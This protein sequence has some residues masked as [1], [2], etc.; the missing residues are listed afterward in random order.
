M[1]F[2]GFLARPSSELA[3]AAGSSFDLAAKETAEDIRTKENNEAEAAK[4][5]AKEAQVAK[6]QEA[7]AAIQR[8]RIQSKVFHNEAQ[9]TAE[10]YS[11]VAKDSTGKYDQAAKDDA[12]S[13]IQDATNYA[14]SLDSAM[15]SGG[16]PP[17]PPP[18]LALRKNY[19][20]SADFV[21]RQRVSDRRAQLG[22]I[23]EGEKIV[24]DKGAP[25]NP[26]LHPDVVG[27]QDSEF[28][29]NNAQQNLSQIQSDR[30]KTEAEVASAQ[31]VMA[32]ESGKDKPDPQ[33][34]LSANAAV[35][36][37]KE[38][39][40][41]LS[42]DEERAGGEVSKAGTEQQ[43]YHA[44]VLRDI[45]GGVWDGYYGEYTPKNALQDLIDKQAVAQPNPDYNKN[46]PGSGLPLIRTMS[47]TDYA[48]PAYRPALIAQIRQQLQQHNVRAN[49]K[50]R[51]SYGY[52]LQLVGGA[53]APAPAQATQ[54]PPTPS[55]GLVATPEATPA[56]NDTPSSGIVPLDANT[57]DDQ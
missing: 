26:V 29:Y 46:G 28:R 14:N 19:P 13:H 4:E 42:K 12:T 40:K 7:R 16:E 6:V 18:S 23:A 15:A 55:L 30:T 51:D 32:A 3:S 5:T 56:S 20:L 9:G 54:T 41:A 22:L 52:L 2:L 24:N 49:P 27:L 11:G 17:P 25:K 38:K 10:Y 31:R 34:I 1:G 44:G 36:S 57:E 53:A 47:A 21:A 37:G 48:D 33:S 39:L 8:A 43:Q 45:M 50:L 35:Q